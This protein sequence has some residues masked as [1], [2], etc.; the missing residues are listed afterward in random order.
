MS[1]RRRQDK[2]AGLTPGKRVKSRF[3]YGYVVT[4]AIFGIWM[5]GWGTY[6]TIFGVFFKPVLTDFGWSR[7]ETT[8]GYSLS[9][10][11]QGALAIIMGWLTDRFGHR[12]VVTVFGSFLGICYLLLSQ[13]SSIWQFQLYY[14][15]LGAVGLSALTVPAMATIA[16]WFVQ[17]QG[18]MTGIAQAGLGVGGLFFAPFSGWLIL[19]YGWR[20]GYTVLG[21][22]IL[23]VIIISG[24]FLRRDPRDIGQLP[25]GAS[26]IRA[27]QVEKPSP[28]PPAAGLSLREVIRTRQFWII[29][30]LYFSF[31]FGRTTFLAHIAAHVQDL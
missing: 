22:T 31:D 30:G 12:L 23:A 8:L 14:A 19:N 15:S 3:F 1:S 11:V 21:I 28:G 26:E 5:T 16:R 17:R 13:V 4:A 20:S 6:S 29:V 24:L 10:L 27:P 9:M 18:L 25:D 2:E 7:A